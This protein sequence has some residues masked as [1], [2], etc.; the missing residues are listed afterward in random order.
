MKSQSGRADERALWGRVGGARVPHQWHAAWDTVVGHVTGG[1]ERARMIEYQRV[2]NREGSLGNRG[3]KR[4]RKVEYQRPGRAGPRGRVGTR[5]GA[6]SGAPG[7]GY[8]D[9]AQ[10]G[11]EA[12]HGLRPCPLS[13]KWCGQ[14]GQARRPGVATGPVSLFQKLVFGIFKS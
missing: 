10:S 14:G 12:E 6:L 2:H 7:L 5:R 8:D 13:G 3:R 9:A 11:R 4:A 1:T